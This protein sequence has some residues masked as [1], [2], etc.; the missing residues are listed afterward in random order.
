[1]TSTDTQGMIIPSE[2]QQISRIEELIHKVF[3]QY[4]LDQEQF[5]NVLVA[6]TEAANNAILHGNSCNPQKKVHIA[7]RVERPMLFFDVIDEGPG[8]NP[9]SLPDPTDPEFIDKPNGRGVFLMRRLADMVEFED[10]GSHVR[11]G[12]RIA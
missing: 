1:M 12:F 10:N 2:I 9:D 8:F 7:Y 6:L 4:G 5:G 11:L 3:H